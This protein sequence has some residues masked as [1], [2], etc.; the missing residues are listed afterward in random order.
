MKITEYMNVEDCFDELD[1]I[2]ESLAENTHKLSA[3]LILLREK[4]DIKPDE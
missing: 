4:I 2:A 3:F 1:N